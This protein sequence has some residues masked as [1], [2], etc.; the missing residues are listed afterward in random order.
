MMF[1]FHVQNF[2]SFFFTI[3]LNH[4]MKIVKNVNNQMAKY[5]NNRLHNFDKIR[6]LKSVFEFRINI[7]F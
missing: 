1:G 6:D 3:I 7:L 4:A 2:R 5:G